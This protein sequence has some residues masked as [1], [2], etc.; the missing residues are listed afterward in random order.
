MRLSDLKTYKQPADPNPERCQS[1]S[2]GCSQVTAG[3]ADV[4]MGRSRFSRHKAAECVVGDVVRFQ[5]APQPQSLQRIRKEGYVNAAAVIVAQRSMQRRLAICADRQRLF[6]LLSISLQNSLPIPRR[7]RAAAFEAFHYRPPRGW[8]LQRI[9]LEARHRPKRIVDERG[10]R[11][12]QYVILYSRIY[13][14]Q[15]SIQ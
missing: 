9:L 12:R 6:E 1:I 5:I 15:R 10:S 4:D 3:G 14:L 8:S 13:F 2:I 7:K 11:H